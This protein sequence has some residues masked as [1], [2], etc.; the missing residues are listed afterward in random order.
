MLV[1]PIGPASHWYDLQ[2]AERCSAEGWLRDA[3]MGDGG[4]IA[5]GLRVDDLHCLFSSSQNTA[6]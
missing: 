5:K 2:P 4:Y 1:F 6:R 3:A